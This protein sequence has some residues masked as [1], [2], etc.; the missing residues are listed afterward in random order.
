M[1]HKPLK[2]Q[3]AGKALPFGMVGLALFVAGYAIARKR[4]EGMVQFSSLSDEGL[5]SQSAMIWPAK[6]NFED[7]QSA[8]RVGEAAFTG[9]NPVWLESSTLGPLAARIRSNLLGLGMGE[10]SM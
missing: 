1:K 10:G 7:H 2:S 9:L 4:N 8:I 3:G 5:R 6:T